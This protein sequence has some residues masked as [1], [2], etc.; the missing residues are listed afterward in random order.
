MYWYRY[1]LWS[2]PTKYIDNCL[3]VFWSRAKL[4]LRSRCLFGVYHRAGSKRGE[5][6]RGAARKPFRSRRWKPINVC[7]ANGKHWETLEQSMEA[8]SEAEYYH[9]TSFRHFLWDFSH[10]VERSLEAGHF[11]TWLKLSDV[12]R[13]SQWRFILASKVFRGGHGSLALIFARLSLYGMLPKS[14]RI[15]ICLQSFLESIILLAHLFFNCTPI[16]YQ[17]NLLFRST[18]LYVRNV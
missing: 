17:N 7:R 12:Y 1:D 3:C 18:H 15:S 5:E 8:F 2:S 13:F 11:S 14:T 9:V 4:V 6:R 10:H 16:Q